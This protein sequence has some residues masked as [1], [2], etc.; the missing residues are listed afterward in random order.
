MQP[1]LAAAGLTGAE[2]T[3]PGAARQAP[4][5]AL[6]HHHH[7]APGFG[8]H[9]PGGGATTLYL[10]NLSGGYLPR[11]TPPQHHPTRVVLPNWSEHRTVQGQQY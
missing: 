3:T 10:D 5:E 7:V 6:T 4:E 8:A 9:C 2:A 11:W 1:E